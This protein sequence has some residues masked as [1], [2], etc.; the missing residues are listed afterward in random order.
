MKKSVKQLKLAKQ[1]TLVVAILRDLYPAAVC[2]LDFV[3][4]WELL[5][6]GILAAQCTDA[7]VNLITPGLFARFPDLA[8]MA[9]ASQAEVE[10]LIRTCGLFRNKAKAIIASSQVLLEKFS[11]QVP[12]NMPDL[13]SLPGVGR[14]IANLLLGDA[15][16][17]AALVVD[18]H[19]ARVSRLIG[20][21]DSENP[22]QIEKDLTAI[23][24]EADWIDYGHLMVEHGRAICI[25]R[26]PRCDICPVAP[27]C[28]FA[29]GS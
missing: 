9:R 23:L 5:V 15:F 10:E 11:S 29:Q 27:H 13:L 4:P 16:G 22:Q 6:A 8:S 20:L 18:T 3:D 7:R 12:Q 14:K 25:A 26:R 1:A 17:I 21:T 28:R 2:T 19:C 24:P